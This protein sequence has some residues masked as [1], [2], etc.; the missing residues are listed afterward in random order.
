MGAIRYFDS[1]RR[2]VRR[3][4]PATRGPQERSQFAAPATGALVASGIALFSPTWPTF[5]LF[6]P[7]LLLACRYHEL[8]HHRAVRRSTWSLILLVV[9]VGISAVWAVAHHTRAIDIAVHTV[10]LIGATAGGVHLW[11]AQQR[12]A[13]AHGRRS[14]E[15]IDEDGLPRWACGGLLAAM[16]VLF[17]LGLL[18]GLASWRAPLALLW[19]LAGAAILVLQLRC[20]PSFPLAAIA[21][22]GAF[23]CAETFRALLQEDPTGDGFFLAAAIVLLVLPLAAYLWFH[24]RVRR[25]F[26]AAEPRPGGPVLASASASD[27]AEQGTRDRGTTIPA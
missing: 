11:S 12:L 1:A 24:P 4:F 13:R 7:I 16:P 27:E 3:T 6:A 22:L 14:R 9:C 17:A 15:R 19:G 21:W 20:H 23:L 18:G 2:F 26:R 25:T 5:L 10:L 8:A